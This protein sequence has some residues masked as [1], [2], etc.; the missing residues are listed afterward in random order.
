MKS[1]SWLQCFCVS[2]PKR[3]ISF[4]LCNSR[5]SCSWKTSLQPQQREG[6]LDFGDALTNFQVNLVY[7]LLFLIVLWSRL[8]DFEQTVSTHPVLL[9]FFSGKVKP[10]QAWVQ[11]SRS[12]LPSLVGETGHEGESHWC[13]GAISTTKPVTG[14]LSQQAGRITLLLFLQGDFISPHH[15]VLQIL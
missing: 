12:S 3:S 2:W 13:P 1:H 6:N 10:H 7:L 9:F 4:N 8:Y 5:F 11:H 15:D 14:V